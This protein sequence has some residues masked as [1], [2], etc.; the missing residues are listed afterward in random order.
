MFEKTN[1]LPVQQQ[2]V[3]TEP[4]QILLQIGVMF[5]A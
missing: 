1:C 2:A 4:M 3:Y 5:T